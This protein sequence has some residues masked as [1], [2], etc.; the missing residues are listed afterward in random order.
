VSIGDKLAIRALDAAGR[1][2]RGVRMRIGIESG[3]NVVQL[4]G[5]KITALAVGTAVIVVAPV[6]GVPGESPPP[7]ASRVVVRVEP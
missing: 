3:N 6:P 1:Q 2:I 5:G 4:Q 7:G